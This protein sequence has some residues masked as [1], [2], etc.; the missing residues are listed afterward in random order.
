MAVLGQPDFNVLTGDG[1]QQNDALESVDILTLGSEDQLDSHLK[2][3]SLDSSLPL[4]RRNSSALPAQGSVFE[5]GVPMRPPHRTTRSPRSRRGSYNMMRSRSTS[6]SPSKHHL[7]RYEMRRATG[8]PRIGYNDKALS[9]R[10]SWVDDDEEDDGDWTAYIDRDEPRFYVSRR[11]PASPPKLM[12]RP[13]G[14]HPPDVARRVIMRDYTPPVTTSTASSPMAQ[15]L[16]TIATPTTSSLHNDKQPKALSAP[17]PNTSSSRGTVSTAPSSGSHLRSV[18]SAGSTPVLAGHRR[19]PPPLAVQVPRSGRHTPDEMSPLPSPMMSPTVVRAAQALAV[20]PDAARM[21]PL[22]SPLA[23]LYQRPVQHVTRRASP[24]MHQQHQLATSETPEPAEETSSNSRRWGS[25]HRT[26]YGVRKGRRPSQSRPASVIDESRCRKCGYND[27]FDLIRCDIC[28]AGFHGSCENPPLTWMPTK[29]FCSGSCFARYQSSAEGQRVF[30]E[31]YMLGTGYLRRYDSGLAQTDLPKA[32]QDYQPRLREEPVMVEQSPVDIGQ[33]VSLRAQPSREDPR[34]EWPA[35]VRYVHFHRSEHPVLHVSWLEPKGKDSYFEDG[36][37]E[38]TE[39][40][41]EMPEPVAPAPPPPPPREPS[42][43]PPA[44]VV[45]EKPEN[46]WV[47][48]P[49]GKRGIRCTCGRIFSSGQALGGHRG[50]CKVPRERQRDRDARAKAQ[51]MGVPYKP[52]AKTTPA[53]RR[54]N[55]SRL[56]KGRAAK[57]TT[58]IIRKP[59]MGELVVDDY[60]PG[61]DEPLVQALGAIVKIHPRATYKLPLSTLAK[62]R[63]DAIRRFSYTT[64]DEAVNS[65][66]LHGPAMLE[67]AGTSQRPLLNHSGPSPMVR[68]Q[69]RTHSEITAQGPAPKRAHY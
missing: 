22:R 13:G 66:K 39:S 62:H 15:P 29:A 32:S 52:P 50:K 54:S 48:L 58:L 69:K 3:D 42:P 19:V 55:A 17:H 5:E 61:E 16:P 21:S 43:P 36:D 4:P 24:L 38:Q 6:T 67:H 30:R 49:N 56:R 28:G 23:A 65:D 44:P 25:A 45:N 31:F 63:F 51:T 41:D 2:S 20:L 37:Q 12:V 64:L 1:L 35:V 7:A 33:V 46:E 40:E 10:S 11:P 27:E 34:S 14:R 9:R 59:R 47:T 57:E 8:S 60:R 68:L 53:P 26:V 18:L